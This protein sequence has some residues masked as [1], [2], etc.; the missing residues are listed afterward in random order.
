[1]T[2]LPLGEIVGTHGLR[3][4]LRVKPFCDGADFARQF[5]TL[6]WDEAGKIPVTPR[7]VRQHKNVLLFVLEGVNHINDAEKL[8]GRTLWFFRDD[9]KLD[10][11]EVF[12]A[13]L[14]GCSVVDADTGRLYGTVAQVE[15]LPAN[16]VWYIEDAL[17]NEYLFPAVSVM[18]DQ[19]D[20]QQRLAR[21]RPIEGIFG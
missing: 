6:Y 13:E 12:V 21:I 18:I 16:D 10:E 15:S 8:R 14:V 17:G 20:T 1:M 3:G 19:I 9:A 11:D 2:F 7:S 4:E 5:K